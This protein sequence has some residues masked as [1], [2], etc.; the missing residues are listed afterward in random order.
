[1]AAQGVRGFEDVRQRRQETDENG[2][3]I[4]REP[5]RTIVRDND[6]IFIRH[7]ENERFRELGGDIRA[8]RRGRD[9]V[10]I[11][12]RGGGEQ[13][14]TFTDENG[15][16]LRRIRRAPDGREVVIIDN[17][18]SGPRLLREDVVSLPPPALRIPRERY[19]VDSDQ[20][21]ETL[22]YET[23]AA[24]PVAP[25]PRRYTL[26]QVR[27]SPDLRAHMRSVDVN[28]ITFD[29][30]VW[31]L[32]PDQIRPL[33]ATAQAIKQ[34]LQR[35]RNEVFLIEGHTDAVGSDVD[36][37]SLSDR[38]AQSVAAALTRDFQI[39]P[40][41]LTTQGYGSQYLKVQTTEASRENRRVTLRRI[42]PL[43][44]GAAAQPR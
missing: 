14:I 34:A 29:T 16:L 8:E 42:T 4:V 37:L 27:Y 23:L 35:N 41:N 10:T 26:D 40:E 21:D 11:Y 2:V 28:T 12:E 6:R 19:V 38:R 31:T 1:M 25:L 32:T 3:H 43:I 24:E 44:A 20:A 7:D 36:N 15:R 9:D 22:I 13:I 30:G 17:G 5:G 33:A 18:A 39:P